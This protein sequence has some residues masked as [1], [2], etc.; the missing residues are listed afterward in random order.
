MYQ[1]G[2]QIVYGTTG[3]C[4]VEAVGPLDMQGAREDVDYYTLS[5]V[6]QGGRL[7]IPVDTAVYHRPVMTKEEAM[8]FIRHIPEVDAVVCENKN[9]R[10][11]NEQYQ[12]YLKS[13]DCTDLVRLIRAVY[14]K[15]KHMAR[16]G[17]HL[18]QVD[19]RSM[20]RAEEML[21]NELASALGIAPGEVKGF[22]T[23]TLEK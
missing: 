22:I 1:V 21:H 3:V 17:R 18:S 15:E 6:Y 14:L 16:A 9:P 13:G 5:P 7:F 8:S 4:R 10:L 11:L 19:E 12:V 2:E 20:K 23:K